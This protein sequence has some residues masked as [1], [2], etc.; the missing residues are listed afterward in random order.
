MAGEVRALD[1][2][3]RLDMACWRKDVNREGERDS[4]VVWTLEKDVQDLAG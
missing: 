4:P 1:V 2:R 3:T